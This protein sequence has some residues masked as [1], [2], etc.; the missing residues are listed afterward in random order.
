MALEKSRQTIHQLEHQLSLGDSAYAKKEADLRSSF[1]RRE[2]ELQDA[3]DELYERNQVCIHAT[4]QF[5][6]FLLIF[7][8]SCCISSC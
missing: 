5:P 7:C 2:R 3:F 8:F 1:S 6:P 4:L